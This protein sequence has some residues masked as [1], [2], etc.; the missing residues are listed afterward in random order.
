MPI[1]LAIPFAE[2]AGITIAGL[3]AAAIADKVNEYIKLNPEDSMTIFKMIT[4][5][6]AGEGL[7]TLFKKKAKKEKEEPSIED[8]EEMGEDLSQTDKAKVM[9]AYGKSKGA[10]K[11]QRMIDI[12]KKLGLAGEEKER[13]KTFDEVEGRYEDSDFEEEKPKP[14]FDYT[15][16]FKADGGR[17][18]FA[19]GG[20]N[21]IGADL[22]D[23]DTEMNQNTEMNRMIPSGGINF[24]DVKNYASIPATYGAALY[25]NYINKNVG[26]N[27]ARAF[28]TDDMNQRLSQQVGDQLPTGVNSGGLTYT[29]F[30]LDPVREYI[31]G[32][33]F[34][35]TRDFN[36]P[37]FEK[38]MSLNSADLANALTLGNLNF[39]KDPSGNI[40]YTGNRFDFPQQT[41][42]NNNPVDIPL[43][44][45]NVNAPQFSFT[46]YLQGNYDLN[47]SPTTDIVVPERIAP[48][49]Y[50]NSAPNFNAD[51][52]R[53]EEDAQYNLPKTNG[54]INS[55]LN[56]KSTV[57][58][59]LL[60]AATKVPG[61][62]L[63]LSGLGSL[64]NLI[65]NSFENRQLIGDGVIVDEFGRSY[66]A[67]ELNKQNALGGY[68]TE[69]ARSSR[70]RD[71]SIRNMLARQAAGKAISETR[72][73]ALQ[74][75]AAREQAAREAATAALAAQNAST[76]GTSGATGGYQSSWGGVDSF[77][78][79]SGTA[80]DMGSF[81]DGGL[82]S[83]FVETK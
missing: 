72:L 52:L 29:D 60:S 8:L 58:Q 66:N 38:A 35:N 50:Y 80:A 67:D 11:R 34:R 64:S 13:Q 70:R 53:K 37:S 42:M 36:P 74:E 49:T 6:S 57:P 10:G 26:E 78:S 75:Q 15:K 48:A 1:A 40:N 2:V 20:E 27:M 22:K 9:K 17:I 82:I 21:I 23:P 55:L 56:M 4:P 59:M 46:D 14:K 16:F 45:L 41:F 19:N 69:A 63:I 43:D 44:E 18:G 25:G 30:G 61:A 31:G 33:E 5:A 71:A 3:S 54:I 79:G 7:S 24:N 47:K 32:G 77:M 81:A 76:Y 83:L 65:G 28:R 12:A 68:Y 62:G 39:N 51:V 73:A